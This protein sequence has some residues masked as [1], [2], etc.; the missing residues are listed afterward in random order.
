[1][2]LYLKGHDCKYAVEQMLL[3]L[4]PGERPE[5]TDSAPEG[6][7]AVVSLS[8]G[9][10]LVTSRCRLTVG[11][12]TFHGRSSALRSDYFADP[13][14]PQR[15]AQRLVK[16]SFYRAA[17]SQ[18]GYRPAWGSITGIRPAKLMTAL[19]EH[20]LSERAALTEF[21]RLYDTDVDKAK[22]CLAA[23][24]ASADAAAGLAERDV[25]LYIGIPFCPT[26]CAYCSFVSQSVAKSL[27][28]IEPFLAALRREMEATAETVAGL[29][30]R[31]RAVYVGGG[32]P[33]TLSPEQLGRLCSWLGE[34]F[35]LG[36]CSEICVEAGRPD[37]VTEEKLAVLRG[38]GV[39]RI[40]INPQTMSDEVLRLIGRGHTAADIVRAYETA[41]DVGGFIINMDLIAGLPGD[42][43]ESFSH[44]LTEVL[45]LGPENITV[46][47]LALKKGSAITLSGAPQATADDVAAELRETQRRLSAAGYVPYYLYRQKFTSGGFENVGWCKKGCENLYNVCIMEELCSIIAMGG[48]ASTKLVSPTGRIERIFCPKYPKEYIEGIDKVC[49]AKKGI[50]EFYHAILSE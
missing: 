31:V 22:L 49:A 27:G 3:T 20:R 30:L 16:L 21:M 4:Y 38:G 11:G 25:C 44:T 24:R 15:V 26:R 42:T 12:E 5:Y 18:S 37:T 40:S 45:A 33:T 2:R 8:V 47:N 41:R 7:G 1:M 32:T 46:H 10:K 39:G 43:T 29:G 14:S 34:L 19:L 23:S 17:V 50:E 9:A 35:D 48:G 6:D 13:L 36:A 28:L